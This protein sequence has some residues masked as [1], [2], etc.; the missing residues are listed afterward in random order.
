MQ[1]VQGIYA[2]IDTCGKFE[3]QQVP[4]QRPTPPACHAWVSWALGTREPRARGLLWRV[5]VRA[6]ARATSW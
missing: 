5:C 4:P 6:R 3:L 2:V 1:V